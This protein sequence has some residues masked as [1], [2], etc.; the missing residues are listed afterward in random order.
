MQDVFDLARHMHELGD[1]MVVKFKVLPWEQMLNIGNASG[2]QIVHSDNVV[3]FF[4]EA[5][6]E[7]RSNK[8]C[9]SGDKYSFFQN[10]GV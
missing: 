1:V 10:S 7:V 5:V 4:E 2:E 8:A 6:A 9:G 3:S